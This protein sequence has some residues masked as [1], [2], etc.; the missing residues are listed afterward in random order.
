MPLPP[1]PD[2]TKE[3]IERQLEV[4]DPADLWGVVQIIADALDLD[5][6]Q[7]FMEMKRGTRRFDGGEAAIMDI[8]D[9]SQSN[10]DRSIDALYRAAILDD[11]LMSFPS[12]S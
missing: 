9:N 2:E 4:L 1:T 12:S 5:L 10:A 7:L 11:H 3:E 8:V 6:V